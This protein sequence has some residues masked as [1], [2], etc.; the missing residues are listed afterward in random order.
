MAKQKGRAFLLKI[1][2]GALGFNAFAGMTAKSLS[3]N[4][5]RIDATTPDPASPEGIMWR[6]TLSGTKSVSMSGD[7]TL[8]GEAA[9]ARAVS[10]AVADDNT[11]DFEAIVPGIGTFSGRFAINIE[12]SGD[13]TTTASISLESTGPVGFVAAV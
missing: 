10:L 5:E 11:D 3:I 13:G 8:V 6:E 9:E 4:G 7:I 1:S 2:D 12:F